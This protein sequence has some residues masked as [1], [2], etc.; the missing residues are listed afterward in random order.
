MNL[1]VAA[2]A[3][4][5]LQR[6][7]SASSRAVFLGLLL[8]FSGFWG[9]GYGIFSA[10]TDSGDLAF[11]LRDL[12]LEPRWLWRLGMGLAGL[13]LYRVIRRQAANV[14]P[15][16]WLLFAAYC[17]VGAVS[18]VTVLFYQGPELAALR[19][20]AQESLLAPVGLLFVAFG[21][22]QSRPYLVPASPAVI[23]VSIAVTVMFWLTLGRGIYGS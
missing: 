1:A 12:S 22:R 18:C 15:N 7:P 3:A 11:V 10:V 9:A 4:I 20:S 13:Y 5:A 6:V 19:E 16:G 17:T 23:V 21:K 14:L 8:A 2:V